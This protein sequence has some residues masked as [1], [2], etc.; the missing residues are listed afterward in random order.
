[1]LT[2]KIFTKYEDGTKSAL[3]ANYGREY[4]ATSDDRGVTINRT[5][6]SAYERLPKW[7]READVREIKEFMAGV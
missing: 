7:K 3:I 4:A 1:M 6:G 2:V 5:N